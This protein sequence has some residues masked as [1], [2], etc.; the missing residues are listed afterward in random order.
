MW[1]KK[2]KNIL[3]GEN[4]KTDNNYFDGL[5]EFIFKKNLDTT[6]RLIKSSMIE[7][8]RNCILFFDGS[9]N[10][11]INTNKKHFEFIKEIYID[12]FNFYTTLRKELEIAELTGVWSN[13]IFTE[14]YATN[15]ED[16]GVNILHSYIKQNPLQPDQT[17]QTEPEPNTIDIGEKTQNKFSNIDIDENL[18]KFL[19]ENFTSTDKRFNDLTKYNQIYRFLNEGRDYNIEHRAYKLIIKELFGFDYLNREIKG[20]TQKHQTQLENLAHTYDNFKK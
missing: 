10:E 16:M 1:R 3:T 4:Y 8:Y 18:L 19:S 6:N 9:T 12:K 13:N 7:K 2:K 11:E 17:Q 15:Y 20:Q 5:K 14:G